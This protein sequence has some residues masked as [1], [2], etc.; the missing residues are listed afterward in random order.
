MFNLLV[1]LATRIPAHSQAFEGL[2]QSL[3]ESFLGRLDMLVVALGRPAPERED[4]GNAQ[5]AHP[6]FS[7]LAAADQGIRELLRTHPLLK[8]EDAEEH[9]NVSVDEEGLAEELAEK[10]ACLLEAFKGERSLAKAEIIGDRRRIGQ[11]C[12]VQRGLTHLPSI[13]FATSDDYSSPITAWNIPCTGNDMQWTQSGTLKAGSLEFSSKTADSVG[14]MLARV[15]QHQFGLLLAMRLELRAQ[16][17]Y[18]IDLAMREGCYVLDSLPSDPD[19]YIAMLG[20]SLAELTAVLEDGLSPRGHRFCLSGLPISL[21]AFLISAYKHIRDINT[22]GYLK[23][24]GAL[25]ALEQVL[26]LIDPLDAIA[27]MDRVRAYYVLAQAGPERLIEAA[28]ECEYRYVPEQYKALL[29]SWYRMDDD[30]V[31]AAGDE[32]AAAGDADDEHRARRKEYQNMVVRLQYLG[33]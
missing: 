7:V 27:S 14:S 25:R 32:N 10:E 20:S 21:Q 22:H 28:R 3:C 33:L 30:A 19:A 17:L 12:L 1:R 8:K 24:Q 2:I 4:N 5:P 15:A 18:R 31:E 29:D 9:D 16:S 13:L 11:F 26:T 23:L 6:F